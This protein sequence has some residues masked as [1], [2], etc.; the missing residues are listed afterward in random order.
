MVNT[1]LF[2]NYNDILIHENYR[3]TKTS[4]HYNHTTTI[5]EPALVISVS[6]HLLQLRFNHVM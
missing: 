2:D 3:L 5:V 4:D 1:A 6:C